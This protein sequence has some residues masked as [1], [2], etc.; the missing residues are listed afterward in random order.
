LIWHLITSEYPPQPGGVSDYTQLVAEGLAAAGDEV[1]VWC[2]S[3]AGEPTSGNGVVVH[4]E[5]GRFGIS[6]LQTVGRLLDEFESPRRLLVQWVPHGYGYRSMNVHFCLWLWHRARQGDIVEIMVHEPYLSFWEGSWKQ[7]GVAL[8]H[9][10][11]TMI[12]LRAARRVWISIPTWESCWRPY[13]LGRSLRFSWLPVASNIPVVDD[14]GRVRTIRARYVQGDGVIL[15]HFGAY[16]ARVGNLLLNYVP[17]LMQTGVPQTMLLLGRGSETMRDEL[18]DKQPTL[19]DRVHASGTLAAPELSLHISAC[20]VMLQPYIDGVS[21]RRTSAMVALAHG[22]PVVTTSGR[23]TEPLWAKS[24]AVAIAPIEDIAALVEA[25]Q[26]LLPDAATK[27]RMGTAA[28]TLYSKRFD[29]PRLVAAL[30][31]LDTSGSPEQ[32]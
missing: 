2:P 18:V 20:D 7:N 28:R 8:V 27:T 26:S 19:A 1:H 13:A 14:P 10:L 25:T 29:L 30:R 9:R 12:L 5:P 16:D 23:L 4:P 11:M 21:T 6:D 22:V 17:A 3:A 24:K 31:G 32:S 15:G